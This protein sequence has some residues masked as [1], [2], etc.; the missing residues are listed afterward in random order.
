[1]SNKF[2]LSASILSADFTCLENQISQARA[3]GIDWVH[4]DVMDG[5]FV[6]NL[7]MGPFIVEACRRATDL[8]LDAHLMINNPERQITPFVAA[9]VESLTVHIENTPHIHGILQQI[10][11]AGCKPG[12][13]INPGTPPESIYSVLHMVDMILVMSVN[14]GYSGQQLLPEVVSKI[15]KIRKELKKIHSQARIQVDGGINPG[16]LSL[17][18]DAGADTIVAAT[19]IFKHPQ[20]IAAGVQSLIQVSLE[21][22]NHG[23]SRDFSVE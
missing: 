3:A 6:P 19:A 2:I 21:Q 17:V 14:P 15:V 20:G 13:A 11:A 4:I 7:T 22:K 8:P 12:I 10:R 23:L 9:G 18:L 16:N 5:Q 1:M